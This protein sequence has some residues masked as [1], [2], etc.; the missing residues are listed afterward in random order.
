[1]PVYIIMFAFNAVSKDNFLKKKNKKNFLSP[2][3]Q[4]FCCLLHFQEI[5]SRRRWCCKNF[6]PLGTRYF[7]FLIFSFFIKHLMGGISPINS[8]SQGMPPIQKSLT[9]VPVPASK[10]LA[11]L[12]LHIQ[13]C[14][15]LRVGGIAITK[16]WPE[17]D[18]QQGF[19]QTSD[20]CILG[21]IDLRE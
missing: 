14:F 2:I 6:G 3:Q 16:V 4:H 13:H 18:P 15:S 20:L 12:A 11:P 10:R 5:F 17:G 1:M 21:A 8:Q 7:N 19:R 9:C